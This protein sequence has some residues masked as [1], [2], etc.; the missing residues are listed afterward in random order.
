[1]HSGVGATLVLV[2]TVS[3]ALADGAHAQ[4]ALDADELAQYRL[5][6]AIFMQFESA[7]RSIA[8][9]T[10]SDPGFT[11]APLFTREIVS[12][13]DA[14]AAAAALE[15]RL[16]A[17][18]VLVRALRAAKMSARDYTKFAIALFAARLAHGFVKAGVLRGV[19]P[20]AA[21]ANVAF[22]QARE[23]EIASLLA[24]LGIDG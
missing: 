6:P 18:P 23:G 24:D 9:A 21:A 12:S 19:P 10:R 14:A 3:A 13:G 16:Q 22:V 7:S 4:T 1:M 2:A 5:T 11:R 17:H 8:A 15:T 20:G